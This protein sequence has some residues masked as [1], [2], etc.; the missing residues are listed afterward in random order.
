MPL[1]RICSIKPQILIFEFIPHLIGNLGNQDC[2]VCYLGCW[3]CI[4][5]KFLV[6]YRAISQLFHCDG[7]VFQLICLHATVKQLICGNCPIVNMLVFD[8]IIL[9]LLWVDSTLGYLLGFDSIIS[10]FLSSNRAVDYLLAS[11]RKVFY[12]RCSD[13]II[14]NLFVCDSFVG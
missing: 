9:Y 11:Y 7:M 8:S 4:R 5:S 10:K 14:C 6:D 12:I 1:H 3:D 13:S 2:L